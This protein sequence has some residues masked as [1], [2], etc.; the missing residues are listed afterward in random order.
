MSFLFPKTRIPK[1]PPIP[2]V[3][4]PPAITAPDKTVETKIRQDVKRRKGRKSTIATSPMGL[5]SEAEVKKTSL[6]GSAE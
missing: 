1:P 3:P 4:P 2:P 5:T 6:L